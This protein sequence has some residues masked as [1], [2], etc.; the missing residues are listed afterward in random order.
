MEIA[1]LIQD[2]LGGR[3]IWRKHSELYKKDHYEA[4]IICAALRKRG[5]KADVWFSLSTF[6][7]YL[8]G[9]KR[10]DIIVF[11]LIENCFERNRPCLVPSVW[12]ICNIP[13]VGNDPY[14]LMLTSD[15]KLF[16]DIC[17]KNG[18]LCPRGIQIDVSNVDDKI[19]A[20][21]SGADLTFPLVLKYRYGSMSYGLRRVETLEELLKESSELL[22][23]EPDSPLLCEEYIA[24]QEVSV[25]IVGTGVSAKALAVL[26]Y[27]DSENHALELYDMK[28]KN[29]YDPFV[30]MVPYPD[31]LPLTNIIKQNSLSLYKYLG[32][33]DMARMDIRVT[34][35]GR[36]YFLEANCIPGLS[37]GGAF[38]PVSYGGQ[39]SFE[40]IIAEIVDSAKTRYQGNRRD[41][42]CQEQM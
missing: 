41:S 20:E 19:V 26:R 10:D 5:Y 18:L 35:E 33:R 4:E 39:Q 32:L 2:D 37:I 31:S 14:A 3:V 29:D 42:I 12:E 36:I 40:D 38:D 34:S 22:G 16:K 1:V 23:I 7:Q 9:S 6:M 21:L 25:P 28:W 11:S 27:T 24:G 8:Y 30:R 15:K 17:L 13:Y